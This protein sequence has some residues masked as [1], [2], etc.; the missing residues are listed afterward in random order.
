MFRKSKIIKGL[1]LLLMVGVLTSAGF[2]AWWKCGEKEKLQKAIGNEQLAISNEGKG[3]KAKSKV[4]VLHIIEENWDDLE[5]HLPKG[6]PMLMTK[7]EVLNY[8]QEYKEKVIKRDVEIKK[9]I[10]DDAKQA[11]KLAISRG[12]VP[13]K[14]QAKLLYIKHEIVYFGKTYYS[15]EEDV[16]PIEAFRGGFSG[17]QKMSFSY[18]YKDVPQKISILL[19]PKEYD[20]VCKKFIPPDWDRFKEIRLVDDLYILFADKIG[21]IRIKYNDKEY[22]LKVGSILELPAKEKILTREEMMRFREKY[23]KYYI[24]KYPW[25]EIGKYRDNEYMYIKYI[26]ATKLRD[27]S[28]PNETFRFGTRVTIINHGFEEIKEN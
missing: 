2:V 7:K 24:K 17:I 26:M 28:V 12:V 18:L 15:K 5:F 22:N 23:F 19:E 6:K 4:L 3:T 9:I 14:T 10:K 25:I 27:I 11:I 20:K 13:E 16:L 1:I 21:N 8:Y